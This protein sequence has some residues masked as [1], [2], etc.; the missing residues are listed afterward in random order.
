MGHRAI[1]NRAQSGE[2]E[3]AR[4]SR[5][6]VAC[7]ARQL[8]PIDSLTGLAR[9]VVHNPSLSFS[10]LTIFVY[11]RFIITSS[12]FS[13]IAKN[14]AEDYIIFIKVSSLYKKKTLKTSGTKI[15]MK[16]V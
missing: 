11:F 3:L 13:T 16:L 14:S 10:I 1:K 12:D 9:L 8:V 7:S 4:Y 2:E 15:V 5:L 6:H